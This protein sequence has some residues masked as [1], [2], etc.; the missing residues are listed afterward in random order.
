MP[1]DP[2]G[3]LLAEADP[4]VLYVDRATCHECQG[5]RVEPVLRGEHARLV[6]TLAFLPVTL[7]VIGIFL[8]NSLTLHSLF[9]IVIGAMLF[10]ALSRGR[11]L[12][13]KDAGDSGDN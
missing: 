7:A 3:S 9:L 4:L 5:L 10:V 6:L 12:G 13:G 11:L 8:Q 1:L 2:A